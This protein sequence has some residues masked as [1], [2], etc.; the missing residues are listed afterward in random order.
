MAPA[1][2]DFSLCSFNTIQSEI[3]TKRE[4]ER[5]RERARERETAN[6][7][8]QN[9]AIQGDPA[10]SNT[11]YD[12]SPHFIYRRIVKKAI[13][14]YYPRVDPCSTPGKQIGF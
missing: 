14:T 1:K 4:R 11:S 10:C 7:Y 12:A 9:T 5:E 3:R 13:L 2:L 8:F 6:Q